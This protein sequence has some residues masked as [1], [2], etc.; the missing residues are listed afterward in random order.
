MPMV[1]RHIVDGEADADDDDEDAY[2]ENADG[3]SSDIC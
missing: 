3:D 1:E 2:D